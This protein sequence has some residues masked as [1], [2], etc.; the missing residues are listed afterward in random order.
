MYVR[1]VVRLIPVVVVAS[2][3]PVFCWSAD[4]ESGELQRVLDRQTRGAE[5]A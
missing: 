2:G 3:I 4:T 1:R 5:L